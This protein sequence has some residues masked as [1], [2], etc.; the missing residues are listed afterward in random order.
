MKRCYSHTQKQ[1]GFTLIEVLISLL[2]LGI[3]LL[4]LS[5]LQLTALR[6]NTSAYNRSVA[7]ALAYD[8]A[9]RMRANKN[10]TEANSYIVAVGTGP[11]NATT[12]INNSCGAAALAAY[13]LDEWKCQLGKHNANGA[14]NGKLQGELPEGVGQITRAGNIFTITIMWD[15]E[16]T[17]NLGT[18]CSGDSSVDLTCFSVSFEP[19]SVL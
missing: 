9:D 1:K 2:I 12:C 18:G 16:R 19:P 17:G 14:C 4:G 5:A 3:G 11:S 7:T 15:D 8:I 10:A 6:H 13:D